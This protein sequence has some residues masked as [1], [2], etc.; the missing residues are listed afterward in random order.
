MY[1]VNSHDVFR[2][3]GADEQVNTAHERNH[4]RTHNKGVNVTFRREIDPT[5]EIPIYG[6]YSDTRAPDIPLVRILRRAIKHAVDPSMDAK[7]MVVYRVALFGKSCAPV[8]IYVYLAKS[9][10][11]FFPAPVRGLEVS[12][13]KKKAENI[14]KTKKKT[15][16]FNSKIKNKSRN[17]T[18]GYLYKIFCIHCSFPIA[19]F[20]FEEN[21]SYKV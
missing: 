3:E 12:L 9:K 1:T 16:I 21:K 4:E 14:K 5:T 19:R 10:R 13:N 11:D 15:I 20:R 17:F 2:A 8:Y 6:D 18:E 7:S